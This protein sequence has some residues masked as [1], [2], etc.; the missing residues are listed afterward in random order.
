MR[1]T[2]Q[3]GAVLAAALL[4][5][6]AVGSASARNLSTSNQN[7]RVT[8]TSIELGTESVIIRCPVTL[9]GSFHARTIA[10]VAGSLVGAVTRHQTKQESCTGG[11]AAGF[12]GTER[13]NGTTPSSTLPWH[14]SYESFAGT[15]PNITSAQFLYSRFRFGIRDTSSF[16]TGQYGTAEDNI[17][18]SATRE[19]GGGI[20]AVAPVEGRNVATLFR[21]DAGFTC[22]AIGRLIGSGQAMLQGTTTRVSIT[23]I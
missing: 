16:C 4:L 22:P 17:V 19:A 13:Y 6:S 14:L 2:R 10:K 7:I 21:R 23:L 18:V 12:N 9:E 8:F 20:T 11:I 15:L 5:A 1:T 3:I